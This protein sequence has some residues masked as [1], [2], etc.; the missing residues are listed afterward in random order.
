MPK[1]NTRPNFIAC[2]LRVSLAALKAKY[3]PGNWSGSTKTSGR[4]PSDQQPDNLSPEDIQKLKKAEAEAL[5]GKPLRGTCRPGRC[6]GAALAPPGR[7]RRA[8]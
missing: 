2:L 4:L 3:D 5:D 8:G 6:N 1:R 7:R